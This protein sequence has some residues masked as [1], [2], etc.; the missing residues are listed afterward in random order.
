MIGKF[1]NY[2]LTD[3]IKV[4]HFLVF[5]IGIFVVPFLG[6]SFSE[7][8]PFIF[9]PIAFD[10][11][12]NGSTTGTSLTVAHTCTGTDRLLIVGVAQNSTT[13]DNITGVTYNSVAMTLAVSQ[14]SSP[15]NN[16]SQLWYLRNPAS[17]NNNIVISASPSTE[18]ASVNASYTGAD[19][20]TQ[21]DATNSNTAESVTSI[22]TSV[23]TVK[24]NCW[25]VIICSTDGGT[26]SASTN[27][28][29]RATSGTRYMIGDNNAAIT[30]AGALSQT[31]TR[32]TSGRMVTAQISI[33]PPQ[34]AVVAGGYAF[35]I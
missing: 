24:D 7:F 16:W 33:M 28:T 31:F 14:G 30:P 22:A 6:S 15:A 23:T 27:V 21:P 3:Y 10:A 25:A 29:S 34:P 19:Q 2:K 11:A 18:M 5:L 4:W 32:D 8:F 13:T 26:V 35:I 17:G 1:L 20:L 12:S 9:L